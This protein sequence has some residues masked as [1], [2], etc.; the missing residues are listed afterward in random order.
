MDTQP[1]KSKNGFVII[2]KKSPRTKEWYVLIQYRSN[3]MTRMPG[4]LGTPGGRYEDDEDS[5]QAAV[6]ETTEEAGFVFEPKHFTKF[7]E[8]KNCDWYT[9]IKNDR[10]K[11][12]SYVDIVSMGEIQDTNILIDRH[13]EWKCLRA[14]TFGHFWMSIKDINNLN[15]HCSSKGNSL[16]MGGLINKV[17]DA[18]KILNL[19]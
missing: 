17:K 13:P 12:H 4:F 11:N 8:G 10:P 2:F 15:L 5:L 9:V 19:K 3:S 14:V 6:R 16:V 1:R 7:S 18:V